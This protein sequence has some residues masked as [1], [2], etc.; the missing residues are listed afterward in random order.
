MFDII[1]VDYFHLLMRG[2]QCTLGRCFAVVDVAVAY[3][4]FFFLVGNDELCSIIL[5]WRESF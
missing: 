2:F 3:F 1:I 5:A 4:G